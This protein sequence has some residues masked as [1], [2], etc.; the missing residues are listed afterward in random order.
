[1]ES[2]ECDFDARR[3]S[4]GRLIGLKLLDG[5][6][7]R[8][9]CLATPHLM[10]DKILAELFRLG[11]Q[12]ARDLRIDAER[13]IVQ[14]SGEPREIGCESSNHVKLRT[15]S[16]DRQPRA[17]LDV[18]QI[19]HH[20][21]A[22]DGLVGRLRVQQIQQ[23]NVEWAF[24]MKRL[25]RPRGYAPAGILRSVPM[26]GSAVLLYRSKRGGVHAGVRQMA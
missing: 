16:E 7:G 1:M 11:G 5:F 18:P 20:L 21:L 24:A 10:H 12:E 17:R 15:E 4:I 19:F 13:F 9:R 26:S 8:R 3:R 25:K 6:D 22:C 14:R 23:E 2:L